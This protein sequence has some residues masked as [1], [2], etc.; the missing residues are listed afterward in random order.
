VL[1]VEIFKQL[2]KYFVNVF[3]VQPYAKRALAYLKTGRE[4]QFQ[5]RCFYRRP[6][7]VHVILTF[8]TN[9]SFHV[10]LAFRF[11][12]YDIRNRRIYNT[13]TK[14]KH[15]FHYNSLFNIFTIIYKMNCL[16]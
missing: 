10:R 12:G 14:L 4:I 6:L 9:Q 1:N 7:K 5:G 11:F 16:I 13:Y 2:P 8:D 3:F 15:H